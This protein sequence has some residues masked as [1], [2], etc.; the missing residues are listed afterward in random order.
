MA[1]RRTH[2]A[3]LVRH[4]A[5]DDAVDA[6]V[7]RSGGGRRST[8]RVARSGVNSD[9]EQNDGAFDGLLLGDV[10]GD[11]HSSGARVLAV[12]ARLRAIR[13][14]VPAAEHPGCAS[15]WWRR[16]GDTARSGQH[17][18]HDAHILAWIV[19]RAW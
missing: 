8:A 15:A 6:G 14:R 3:L 9:P 18:Y 12:P 17:D 7:A 16:H 2:A 1:R 4:A 11:G 19:C 5:S 10:N 13:S